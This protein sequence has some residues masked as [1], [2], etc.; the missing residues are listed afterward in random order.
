MLG[1]L[2]VCH[3]DLGVELNHWIPVASVLDFF[4]PLVLVVDAVEPAINEG[5]A[6]MAVTVP[7][8]AKKWRLVNCIEGLVLVLGDIG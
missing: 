2:T 4:V 5:V 1:A 6:A 8:V 7:R 3:V